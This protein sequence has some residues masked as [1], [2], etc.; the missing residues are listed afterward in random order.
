M[1]CRA[2]TSPPTTIGLVLL[3]KTI[4]SQ[5]FPREGFT[6]EAMDVAVKALITEPTLTI[7][8]KYMNPVQAPN[9][10]NVIMASNEDWSCRRRSA[11]SVMWCSTSQRSERVTGIT[12]MR[13]TLNGTPGKKP[14]APSLKVRK[15][16]ARLEQRSDNK[17]LKQSAQ[18]RA[19]DETETGR[20]GKP[21]LVR[22]GRG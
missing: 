8:G 13:A 20:R 22:R 18:R 2:A 21:V 19:A 12:S 3:A 15:G 17:P 10:L 6:L 1:S 7:E 4:P 5:G 14:P 11:K 9:M 16:R